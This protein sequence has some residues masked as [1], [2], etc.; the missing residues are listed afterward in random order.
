[1]IETKAPF[2][3]VMCGD[4]EVSTKNMARHLGVKALP[5]FLQCDPLPRGVKPG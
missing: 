1:M 4:K 3:V 2:I 5:D